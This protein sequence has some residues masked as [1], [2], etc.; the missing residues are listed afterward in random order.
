MREG[1]AKLGDNLDSAQ[2]PGGNAMCSDASFSARP[3]CAL[4]IA[5]TPIRDKSRFRPSLEF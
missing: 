1:G 4:N 2:M 3:I 5:M